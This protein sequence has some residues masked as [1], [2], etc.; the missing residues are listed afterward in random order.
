MSHMI[1]AEKSLTPIF[2]AALKI[3]PR[4]VSNTTAFR[5]GQLFIISP[6]VEVNTNQELV[7]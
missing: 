4:W 3:D 7:F 6:L 2:R 5:L 1:P